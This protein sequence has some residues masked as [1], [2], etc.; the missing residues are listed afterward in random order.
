MNLYA[1]AEKSILMYE[2]VIIYL[3]IFVYYRFQ[4]PRQNS[5]INPRYE[6]IGELYSERMEVVRDQG[7]ICSF[8]APIQ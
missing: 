8:R 6:N 2:L 4:S 5:V 3:I 1:H 7:F